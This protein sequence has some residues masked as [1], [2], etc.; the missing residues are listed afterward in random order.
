MDLLIEHE[1]GLKKKP[2]LLY[3]VDERYFDE[4]DETSYPTD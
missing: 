2:A 4:E 1:I 3:E